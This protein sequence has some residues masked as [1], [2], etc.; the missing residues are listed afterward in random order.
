[1]GAHEL[2]EGEFLVSDERSLLDFGVVHGFLS[3][4]HWS[5][6]IPR[7]VVEKAA[8]NS[9]TFGVYATGGG[10]CEQV[11]YARVVSDLATYAYVADVFVLEAWRGRGLSKLLM[12]AIVAHPELQGLRRWMLM[13][14]DAHGLYAQFGFTGLVDPSRAMERLDQR[15]YERGAAGAGEGNAG[16]SSA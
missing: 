8:A 13:T 3:E 11:G 14:R 4:C 9:V 6:G 2:R 7:A 12:R 10:R 15:V 1:M 5:K 16:G